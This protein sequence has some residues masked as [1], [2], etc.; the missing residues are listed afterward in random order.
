VTLDIVIKAR[1][2]PVGISAQ[3][4]ELIVFMWVLRLTAGLRVNICMD[5]KYAFAAIHVHGA[6][7]KER[8]LINLGGEGVKHGQDILEL[9]EAVWAPKRVVVMYC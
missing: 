1:L 6:L 4:A 3:K 7:Y 9:L 8:V 5:S 2:L